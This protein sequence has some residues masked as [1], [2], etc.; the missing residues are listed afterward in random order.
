MEITELLNLWS[1][2]ETEALDALMERVFQEL[3]KVAE[4]HFYREPVGHTL[5]PTALVNEV[6][7]Q[8]HRQREIHLENRAQ[9]LAFSAQLMRRILV[10]H[11]RARLTQ[12]RGGDV[13]RVPLQEVSASAEVRDVDLLA[14]DDSLKDLAR[15]DPE[16]SRVIE[17]RFFGGLTHEEIAEIEDI[18]VSSV[19]RRWRVAKLWLYRELAGTPT[20]SRDD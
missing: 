8:L 7:L 15:M 19:R 9:F 10:D 6:F 12:K 16:G 13:L 2:G 20:A 5:Q 18:S 17:L 3:H 11:A 4:R 1:R 14:L